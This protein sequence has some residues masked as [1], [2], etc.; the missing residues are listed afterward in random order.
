MPLSLQDTAGRWRAE[1]TP[2]RA[3]VAYETR[4]TDVVGVQLLLLSL[5]EHAR[6]ADGRPR[7]VL[8]FFPGAPAD[9]VDWLAGQP[10]VDLVEPPPGLMGGWNMKPA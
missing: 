4:L 5:A 2:M 9:L 10:Q 1:G 3:V 8:L 6:D 7:R